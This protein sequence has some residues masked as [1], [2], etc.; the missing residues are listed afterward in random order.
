MR[1]HKTFAVGVFLFFLINLIF[2]F[3]CSKTEQKAGENDKTKAINEEKPCAAWYYFAADTADAVQI[4]KTESPFEIKPEKYRPW[5]EA[6]RISGLAVM[7]NPPLLL[8]NKKGIIHGF[9]LDENPQTDINSFFAEKTAAGFYKTNAGN[10]IRFYNNSIFSTVP[11]TEEQPCLCRYNIVSK[12]ITPAVFPHHFGLKKDAQLTGLEFD[13]KWFAAFKTEKNEKVEFDYFSF[14][15]MNNLINGNYTKIG[16][17][18]FIEHTKPINVNSH[19]AETKVITEFAEIL[20]REDD[21]NIQVELFSD[22]LKNKL[23]LIKTDNAL[24]EQENKNTTACAAELTANNNGGIS[25]AILFN[26]GKLFLKK[27][28]IWSMLQLPSLPENFSYTYFTI[29]DDI[30]LAGWEEQRFFEIGR[31]GFLQYK[32]QL[33]R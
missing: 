24:E 21:G 25:K 31:A 7:Y 28:E 27:D 26:T 19:K 3:S 10:L 9:T 33:L 2:I 6:V 29:K 12:E 13:E 30:V 5:T 23:L 16:Q 20:R 18:E 14:S 15:D 22:N 17:D 32:L 4:L 1:L 8:I 11:E